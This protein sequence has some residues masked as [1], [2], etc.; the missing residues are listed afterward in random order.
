MPNHKTR[1][2]ELIIC[3]SYGSDNGNWWT[4]DVDIPI[5]T[6]EEN[7]ERVAKNILQ[8]ESEGQLGEMIVHIGLYNVLPL[9]ELDEWYYDTEEEEE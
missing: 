8:I 9:E 1:P 2:V 6:P 4:S 7:I 3:E 5:D